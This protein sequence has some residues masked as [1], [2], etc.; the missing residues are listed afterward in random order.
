[1]MRIARTGKACISLGGGRKSD[2]PYTHD[3]ATCTNNH[4]GVRMSNLLYTHDTA[5]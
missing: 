1:M 5:S 2:L 3:N 4:G